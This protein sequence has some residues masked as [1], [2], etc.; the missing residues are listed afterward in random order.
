ML[1]NMTPTKILMHLREVIETT[2][3]LGTPNRPELPSQE[4]I[5]NF[6]SATRRRLD[7]N[8][9]GSGT[10]NCEFLK[11]IAL[12]HVLICLLQTKLSLRGVLTSMHAALF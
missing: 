4:Q 12:F 3:P 9:S 7:K 6:K 8:L 11:W 10:K 2:W 5:K 1:D